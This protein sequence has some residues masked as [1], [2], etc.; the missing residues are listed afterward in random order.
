MQVKC[1]EIICHGAGPSD[2]NS[3]CSVLGNLATGHKLPLLGTSC[4]LCIIFS[5]FLV[6]GKLR[7]KYL[8]KNLK[9]IK[10]LRKIN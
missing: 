4:R 8:G 3:F 10:F 1:Q 5:V 6:K 7:V 2:S 9:E